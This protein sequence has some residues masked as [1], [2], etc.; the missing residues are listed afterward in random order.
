MPVNY[1]LSSGPKETWDKFH[2]VPVA[3]P[4]TSYP[5]PTLNLSY[6]EA[7]LPFPSLSLPPASH[8]YI[9]LLF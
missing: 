3:P 4:S 9:N 1:V 5:T 8:S 2:S 6:P 7:G